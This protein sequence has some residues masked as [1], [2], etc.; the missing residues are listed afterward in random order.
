MKL[1]GSMTA[2]QLERACRAMARISDD[3][4]KE[5]EERRKLVEE[6][7]WDGTVRLEAVAPPDDGAIITK[8][9]GLARSR[10]WKR[11][12]P[13]PSGL[14]ALVEICRVFLEMPEPKHPAAADGCER[15]RVPGCWCMCRTPSGSPGPEGEGEGPALV[16]G[17]GLPDAI[18]RRITCDASLAVSADGPDGGVWS[19]GRRS[20]VVPWPMRVALMQPR[21]GLR[22][23]GVSGDPACGCSSHRAL[24]R[25][26]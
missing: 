19:I 1:A 14:D 12:D 2:A 15:R 8:A 17:H 21:R 3:K 16:E 13:H 23:P 10:L 7:D 24:G 25:W 22:V 9:L 18:V 6:T 5:W 11:G 4:V 26:R 20:R